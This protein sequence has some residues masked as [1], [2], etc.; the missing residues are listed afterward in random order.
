M[1]MRLRFLVIFV[2]ALLG[3]P[4]LPLYI[5]RTLMRS[6]LVGGAGDRID[7][8]WALRTLSEF[9]ADYRYFRSEQQPELWLAVNIALA[10]LYAALIAVALDRLIAA[11][12]QR[13]A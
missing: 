1:K 3:V 7:Y 13:R 2:A 10:I 5:E 6:M 8:G 12:M 11:A 4:N 9:W